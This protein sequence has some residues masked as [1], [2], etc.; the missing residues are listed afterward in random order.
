MKYSKE[1]NGVYHAKN[2]TYTYLVEFNNGISGC[3]LKNGNNAR[4]NNFD[5]FFTTSD[6]NKNSD[7][8]D[9]VLADE[10]HTNWLKS[11]KKIGKFTLEIKQIE[12]VE[13]LLF[14]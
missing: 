3:G 13:P 6:F 5:V 2:H 14:N 1:L 8:Y 11:C 4:D 12:L 7:G 10:R 9:Y